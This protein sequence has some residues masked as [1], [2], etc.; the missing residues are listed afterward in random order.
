MMRVKI[1]NRVWGMSKEEYNKLILVAK[2][3]MPFGI[4]A[5]EKGN[6]A[7][8]RNDICKSKTQLKSIIRGYKQ[9]GFKVYF[10][11]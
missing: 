8:M 1:I 6:Y 10:N 3:Q 2:E 5:V 7:E 4:Y 11:G 9:Q